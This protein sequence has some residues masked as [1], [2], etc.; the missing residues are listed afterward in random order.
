MWCRSAAPGASASARSKS[1]PASLGRS[2]RTSSSA[3]AKCQ[4]WSRSALG[5]G[6]QAGQSGAGAVHLTGGDGG[7][8]LDGRVRAEGG[9]ELVQPQ[10]L[11]P[12]G[13]L[14]RRRQ[15][16]ARGDRRLQLVAVGAS[17]RRRQRAVQRGDAV[18]DVGPP[19]PPAVLFGQGDQLAVGRQPRRPRWRPSA[20][21]APAAPRSSGRGASR[22]ATGPGARPR[23]TVRGGPPPPGGRGGRRCTRGG[24]PQRHLQGARAA[25]PRPGCDTGCLAAAIFCLARTRRLA[26]VGSATSRT[27]ATS[28][29]ARPHNVRR[30]SATLAS[31]D[32]AG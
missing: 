17:V 27:R 14:V 22:P 24:P 28:S 2:S 15:G 16:V 7:V 11:P 6:V 31:I 5:D 29:V 19:P 12:I 21:A 10:H 9:E 3:R 20:A 26:M 1:L 23:R 32:S 18:V 4:R 8:Q 30:A 25:R 13:G